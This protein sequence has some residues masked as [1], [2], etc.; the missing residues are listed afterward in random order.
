EGLA[1]PRLPRT[2]SRTDLLQEADPTRHVRRALSK[3]M[4]FAAWGMV[5]CVIPLLGLIFGMIAIGKASIVDSESSTLVADKSQKVKRAGIIAVVLSVAVA[6]LYGVGYYFIYQNHQE[7]VRAEARAQI[8]ANQ[9][10]EEAEQKQKEAERQEALERQSRLDD[11]LNLIYEAYKKDWDANVN[12]LGRADGRLPT[13]LAQQLED[14]LT[15][16]REECHRRS[17]AGT[18]PEFP[19]Y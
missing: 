18:L 6:A 11:C 16:A 7:E 5:G 8:E 2:R 13:D 15:Y 17:E 10:Q 4:S 3:G 19:T 14:Q 9:R 1:L 12:D